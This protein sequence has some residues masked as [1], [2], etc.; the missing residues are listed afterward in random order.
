[1]SNRTQVEKAYDT[2]SRIE[3]VPTRCVRSSGTDGTSAVLFTFT[4]SGTTAIDPLPS[5]E[6]RETVRK[7]LLELEKRYRL[8]SKDFYD[9][10][11]KGDTQDIENPLRWVI[12]WELWTEGYKTGL[13][14]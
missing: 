8:K 3:S 4:N 11:K 14:F 12:L 13:E 7:N 10:W 9:R 6:P 2:T 1:M 5:I